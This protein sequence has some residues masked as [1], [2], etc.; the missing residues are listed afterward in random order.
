ME[1]TLVTE[2]RLIQ[3]LEEL[4][5]IDRLVDWNARLPS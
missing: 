2:P 1:P 4:K 5:K 3:I